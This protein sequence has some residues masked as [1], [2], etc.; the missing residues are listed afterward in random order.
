MERL[1]TLLEARVVELERTLGT[2]RDDAAA[3]AAEAEAAFQAR[4]TALSSQAEDRY[5]V[6][7][8]LLVISNGS[9]QVGLHS[10]SH[11]DSLH[12]ISHTDTH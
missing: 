1:T 2:T 7:R 5:K 4:I 12:A 8:D 10:I 3:E 9:L 6:K 11:T